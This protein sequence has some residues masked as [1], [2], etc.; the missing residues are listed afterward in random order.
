MV[1]KYF[2]SNKDVSAHTHTIQLIIAYNTVNY[3][4]HLA[5]LN[6]LIK[7]TSNIRKKTKP[8]I[9]ADHQLIKKRRQN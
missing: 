4:R 6:K 8:I 1:Q 9:E 3:K 2:K 5:V 7:K